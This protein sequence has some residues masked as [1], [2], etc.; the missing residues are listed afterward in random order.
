MSEQVTIELLKASW[1]PSITTTLIPSWAIS[2][3]TASST[4]QG[5]PGRAVTGIPGRRK[6][7]QA[8]QNDLKGSRMCIMGMT[9]TGLV[10]ISASLNGHLQAHLRP[11]NTSRCAALTCLSL[12]RARSSVRILSGRSWSDQQGQPSLPVRLSERV[13]ALQSAAQIST[14][15]RHCL[16]PPH[17]SVNKKPAVSLTIVTLQW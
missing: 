6:C 5:A 16:I 8:W 1:R 11:V 3:M 2:Q 4:C 17:R 13:S 7:G 15:A 10:V 14:R 12:H 9:S